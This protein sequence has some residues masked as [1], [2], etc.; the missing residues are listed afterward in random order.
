MAWSK[1]SASSRGYGSAWR[2]LRNRI[3]QRDNELCQVCIKRNLLTKAREVDHILS[4]A[5]GGTDD[6]S[7]L[8]SICLACHSRKSIEERGFKYKPQTGLDGWPIEE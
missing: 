8:Q 4:K 5:D 2:K 7:N 1:E 3:M 6:E